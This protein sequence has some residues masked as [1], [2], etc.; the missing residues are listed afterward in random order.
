MSTVFFNLVTADHVPMAAASWASFRPHNP[1]IPY[2]L[3]VLDADSQIDQDLDGKFS[4]RSIDHVH[5]PFREQLYSYY[6]KALLAC[7]LRVFVA[8]HELFERDQTHVFL[9]DSDIL[10]SGPFDRE[11]ASLSTSP[12]IIAAHTQAPC[13]IDGFRTADTAFMRHGFVNAGFYGLRRCQ[14]T[15]HLLTWLKAWSYFYGFDD[16]NTGQFTDQKLWDLAT[17]YFPAYIKILN[18]HEINVGYWNMF[19]KD[20]QKID[21]TYV[22]KDKPIT[23]FHLSGFNPDSDGHF[24][25]ASQQRVKPDRFPIVRSIFEEFGALY[26][27]QY[28]R[29]K[30]LKD[31]T[32]YPVPDTQDKD[33]FETVEPY[34]MEGVAQE[35]G[36]IID[37]TTKPPVRVDGV[38]GLTGDCVL[39][40]NDQPDESAQSDMKE[41]VSFIEASGRQ[42]YVIGDSHRSLAP[43]TKPSPRCRYAG[44][45]EGIGKIATADFVIAGWL[46]ESDLQLLARPLHQSVPILGL[47]SECLRKLG[48]HVAN[49][50]SDL[51]T[52]IESALSNEHHLSAARQA[53]RH[54]FEQEVKR[55]LYD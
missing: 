48:L 43:I 36:N 2:R 51:V 28:E 18:D 41:L 17:R 25:G 27:T 29:F 10:V 6:S 22:N 11:I 12:A 54:A 42:L 21:G 5:I 31:M 34:L 14:E 30:T 23:F 52:H 7:N 1:D 9:L 40:C 26:D 50:V 39:I 45:K 47:H 32:T 3:Y 33:A 20:V 15:R 24:R 38:E 37:L 16:P 8:Y 13:P 35:F 49:T 19:Q 4:I 44:P 55:M 53:S 46:S